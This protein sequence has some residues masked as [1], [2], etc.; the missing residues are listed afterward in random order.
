M[1]EIIKNIEKDKL[2]LKPEKLLEKYS[3]FEKYYPKLYEIITTMS[4]DYYS[5]MLKEL[6]T[7]FKMVNEG[8]VPLGVMDIILGAKSVE[9]LKDDPTESVDECKIEDTF[10]IVMKEADRNGSTSAVNFIQGMKTSGKINK[11]EFNKLNA[12]LAE[13]FD[14][15]KK[16]YNY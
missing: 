4:S 10:K 3:E 7:A 9:K 13:Q 2:V 16:E 12:R 1:E 14:L 15:L 6:L 5:G 11:K 8:A